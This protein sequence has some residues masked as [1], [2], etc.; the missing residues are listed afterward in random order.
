MFSLLKSSAGTYSVRLQFV[1][2]TLE[3]M[4]KA[5]PLTIQNPPVIVDLFVP[6]CSASREGYPCT[7]S[8]FK[9]VTNGAIDMSFVEKPR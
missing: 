8:D 7:W 6:G 3:Q 2:Q 1:T 5:T 4:N 9:Q